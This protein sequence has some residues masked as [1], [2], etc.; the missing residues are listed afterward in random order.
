MV[1]LQRDFSLY[2][3]NMFDTGQAARV[4]QLSG[5]GLAFLLQKYCNGT[6]DKKYQ[7]A[8]WRQRPLLAE[9]VKYA[10]ED[11]HYLL[12]IYDCIRKDLITEGAKKTSNLTTLLE[13]VHKKSN[14]LCLAT[15]EKP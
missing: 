9:M 15:W 1:W 6:A 12:H 10:R 4:L 7:L 8:D 14:A 2:L 13:Q 3:V 11:T 5:F